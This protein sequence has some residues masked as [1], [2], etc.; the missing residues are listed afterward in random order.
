MFSIFMLDSSMVS[1][2]CMEHFCY[3][4]RQLQENMCRTPL[5]CVIPP[6]LSDSTERVN[7]S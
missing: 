2:E 4:D 1:V 5:G 3:L 6:S 7:M